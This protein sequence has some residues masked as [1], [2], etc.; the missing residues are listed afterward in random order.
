M[1]Q[2][3]LLI[4]T[5]I[6]SQIGQRSLRNMPTTLT[7]GKLSRL[8]LEK[9]ARMRPHIKVVTL[10]S[11]WISTQATIYTAILTLGASME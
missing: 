3:L 6:T 7:C 4:R 5:R 9:M 11:S 8:L 10:M 1:E 2:A